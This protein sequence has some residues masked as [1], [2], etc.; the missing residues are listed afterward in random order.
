MKDDA[1]LW[2]EGSSAGCLCS[3]VT[4]AAPAQM[5]SSNCCPR[6]DFNP[7]N[8]LGLS[9]LLLSRRNDTRVETT[10]H[11]PEHRNTHF[12]VQKSAYCPFASLNLHILIQWWFWFYY[13][14]LR[15]FDSCISGEESL[16]NAPVLWNVTGSLRLQ[17]GTLLPPWVLYTRSEVI[18]IRLLILIEK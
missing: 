14:N 11:I 3:S 5:C 13:W 4:E 2:Q 10:H 9:C 18:L 15:A 1:D 16:D 7:H 17:R 6:R 12:W 8:I